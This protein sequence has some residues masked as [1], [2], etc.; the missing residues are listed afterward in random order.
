[1]T[2]AINI[3]FSDLNLKVICIYSGD[4]CLLYSSRA[5]GILNRA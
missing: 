3:F 4:Y 1:M 2:S 5:T